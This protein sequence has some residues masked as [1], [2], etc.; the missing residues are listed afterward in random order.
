MLM[1]LVSSL[2]MVPVALASAIVALVALVSPTVKA[3]VASWVR[4]PL[5]VTVKV[6][7]SRPQGIVTVPVFAT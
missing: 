7:W 3:S 4:S 1:V 5:T 6:R 2:V